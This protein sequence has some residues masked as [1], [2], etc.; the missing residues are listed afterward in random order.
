M[1]ATPTPATLIA[2]G[3]AAAGRA[4][5]GDPR[6]WKAEVL[7][8]AYQL[9]DGVKRGTAPATLKEAANDIIHAAAIIERTGAVPAGGYRTPGPETVRVAA[10]SVTGMIGSAA[11]SVFSGR[12]SATAAGT[13]AITAAKVPA[14]LTLTKIP[15]APPADA[16]NAVAQAAWGALTT[17]VTALNRI[18]TAA[19]EEFEETG[20][21]SE[22]RKAAIAVAEQRYNADL[23]TF[24]KYVTT[25]GGNATAAAVSS[26]EKIVKKAGADPVA[27]PP[28]PE[29]ATSAHTEWEGLQ[30]QREALLEQKGAFKAAHSD[31][32]GTAVNEGSVKAITT[33]ETTYNAAVAAYKKKYVS[34]LGA[35]RSQAVATAATA[36]E[37]K[38]ER[39]A[40][41]TAE[42]QARVDAEELFNTWA[43]EKI[44]KPLTPGTPRTKYLD[45]I[46]PAK[47]NLIAAYIRNATDAELV[48][49]KARYTEAVAQFKRDATYQSTLNYARGITTGRRE[50][51]NEE[52]A[53]RTTAAQLVKAVDASIKAAGITKPS[54]PL[55]IFPKA[56]EAYV[57]VQR[58][59]DAYTTAFTAD[60]A[61]GAGATRDALAA[62]E[63]AVATYNQRAEVAA[64]ELKKEADAFA[65]ISVPWRP[66]FP[67][68]LEFYTNNLAPG[69]ENYTSVINT[70]K[71]KLAAI[72]EGRDGVAETVAYEA[73]RTVYTQALDDYS[74]ITDKNKAQKGYQ[75]EAEAAIEKP[76]RKP[77]FP[78][79]RRAYE[80]T[81][82]DALY[83]TVIG[84]YVT[85]RSQ[86]I[87]DPLAP[88]GNGGP[89][90][91]MRAKTAYDAA[92]AAVKTRLS[93]ASTANYLRNIPTAERTRLDAATTAAKDAKAAAEKRKHEA[94]KAFSY[95]EPTPRGPHTNADVE[96]FRKDLEKTYVGLLRQQQTAKANATTRAAYKADADTY[97]ANLIAYKG[98]AKNP[99]DAKY[100]DIKKKYKLIN[101]FIADIGDGTE[102]A[103]SHP[104]TALYP[105]R[106]AYLRAQLASQSDAT[107]ENLAG[108]YAAVNAVTKGP[109]R[110]A[111]LAYIN[112]ESHAN[113]R[114]GAEGGAAFNAA[115]SILAPT[116]TPFRGGGRKTR[117]RSRHLG[118]KTRRRN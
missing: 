1:S 107:L 57:Y 50:E 17:Q 110:R 63:S 66:V 14:F 102:K 15:Y 70:Y 103:A 76:M 69:S 89:S 22:A 16:T 38:A 36:A 82:I 56:V 94:Q 100:A 53:E 75:K 113:L 96:A 10:P 88:N 29:E 8:V 52:S 4:A 116:R 32:A 24:K 48:P 97:A 49:L 86:G 104:D 108:Q 46:E 9:A 11:R 13:P 33:A 80:E 99:G 41:T 43:P 58:A 74:A 47:E 98:L 109:A 28:E 27:L 5:A 72:A 59:Y 115:L 112:D 87:A 54:P 25:F 118:R 55:R 21:I 105:A 64:S 3:V 73:A 31:L 101:Q 106:E 65:G 37:A 67:S 91:T 61:S 111:V 40:A 62:Y 44:S 85:A 79:A 117:H 51:L 26:R 114:E 19:V 60:P 30:A 35:N 90:Q 34:F 68:F 81:G 18:K 42:K 7:Q 95:V 39:N 93:Y 84:A 6:V 23:A 77:I 83:A 71:A 12:G 92:L 2:A 20:T 78:A 45:L